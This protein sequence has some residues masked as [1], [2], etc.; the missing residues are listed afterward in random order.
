MKIFPFLIA[1][2]LLPIILFAAILTGTVR[3][4]ANGQAIE[5]V[6]V[7]ASKLKAVTAKDGAYLFPNLFPGNYKVNFSRYGYA[8]QSSAVTLQTDSLQLNVELTALPISFPGITVTGERPEAVPA[9]RVR[10]PSEEAQDVPGTVR[11][12]FKVLQTLPGVT[13][14]TDFAGWLFVRGGDA[15][16]N[17]YLMDNGEVL[18]PYHL[19]GLESVVNQDALGSLS[20]SAG[21]FSARY[22]NRLSSVVD[23]KNREPG[24]EIGT[25]KA[26]ASVDPLSASG[27]YDLRLTPG[28]AVFIAGR[29]N[30]L[31]QFL[32]RTDFEGAVV[33]P[34]FSDLLAKWSG[35]AGAHSFSLTELSTRDGARVTIPVEEE[36]PPETL[37]VSTASAGN[38]LAFSWAFH[39]PGFEQTFSAYLGDSREDFNG[40]AVGNEWHDHRTDRILG[41]RDEAT[42]IPLP[43]SK[44]RLGL[45][46][47]EEKVDE[48]RM[49]PENFLNFEG[50]IIAF[51]ARASSSLL[52]PYLETEQTWQGLTVQ[53][54]GRLDYS[55]EASKGAFSPRVMVAWELASGKLYLAGGRY[56]QFPSP[57]YIALGARA[58]ER[59]SHFI[60]GWEKAEGPGTL[61]IETYY[62]P[63]KNLISYG[64]EGA[65]GNQGWGRSS[66]IEL[67]VRRE[68]GKGLSGWGSL[69]LSRSERVDLGDSVLSRFWADQPGIVNLVLNYA[70]SRRAMIGLRFRGSSGP[71]ST[72]ILGRTY[73]DS[74]FTW[75]PVYGPRNSER[76]ASYQRVDLRAERRLTWLGAQLTVY[77]EVLNLANHQNLQG[78]IYNSHY[79]ERAPFYMIPRIP[80]VGLEAEW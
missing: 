78:Y 6:T 48:D 49:R 74:T 2:L 45:E 4:K 57:E 69:A 3:D 43:S 76:L 36:P 47:Q 46:V 33:R 42:L 72:P 19:L 38:L 10:I 1:F 56:A 60:L 51:T 34:H 17:L 7:K 37:R 41:V 65:I 61:R 28:N 27:T 75:N 62:K 31:D 32:K 18:L 66:G 50:E 79:S 13:T 53:A 52:S 71:A 35:R 29:W 63:M 5:G 22:G 67:F 64:G 11:D 68:R 70:F 40:N 80:F 8:S 21:G 16:E 77:G 73:D 59:A 58:P 25:G 23:I 24:P 44:I 54:G 9:S 30:Y 15:S 26:R 14:P 39:K 20:F 12:A 55:T